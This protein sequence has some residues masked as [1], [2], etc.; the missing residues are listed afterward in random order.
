M[1][2]TLGQVVEIGVITTSKPITVFLT[3]RQGESSRTQQPDITQ[4]YDVSVN[5]IDVVENG[6]R[7]FVW[8]FRVHF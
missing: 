7:G 4:R 3:G 6:T 5:L 8:P 2:T 1:D